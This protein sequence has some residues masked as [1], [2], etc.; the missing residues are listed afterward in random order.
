M[1][2]T[3]AFALLITF[4]FTP[5]YLSAFQI[6]SQGDINITGQVRADIN[7]LSATGYYGS[8]EGERDLSNNNLCLGL[9]AGYNNFKINVLTHTSYFYDHTDLG[10]NDE[11]VTRLANG[12][13]SYENDWLMLKLGRQFWGERDTLLPYYGPYE[14]P[15]VFTPSY[16]DALSGAAAFGVFKFDFLAGRETKSS[17]Q[18][19]SG[20]RLV[21]AGLE[22]LF[23]KRLRLQLTAHLYYDYSGDMLLDDQTYYLGVHSTV[24][25]DEFTSLYLSYSHNRGESEYWGIADKQKY[26]GNR[27]LA[28]LKTGKEYG[29]GTYG[30][31]FMYVRDY[32]GYL[33]GGGENGFTHLGFIYTGLNWR[34]GSWPY[35]G[36]AGSVINI[37][38]YNLGGKFDLKVVPLS[39]SVDLYSIRTVD[40]FYS[41]KDNIGSEIDIKL[42][43]IPSE[44]LTFFAGYS[45]FEPGNLYT[46]ISRKRTMEMFFAGM[47][48]KL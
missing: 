37:E 32:P 18:M 9:G 7:Y 27:F 44:N 29:Y 21:Y 48:I 10:S 23:W 16:I 36:I 19:D 39:L 38:A 22:G 41:G 2:Y 35:S 46:S 8:P 20:S 25:L 13:V 11:S 28:K 1:F 12:F 47:S 34:N 3:R 5:F 45:K 40:K 24:L 17:T 42:E 4:L 14:S 43:Y 30:A 26:F 31:H 33:W 15:N 6:F